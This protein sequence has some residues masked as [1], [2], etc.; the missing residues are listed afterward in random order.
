MRSSLYKLYKHTEQIKT[1]VRG[2]T[3]PMGRFFLLMTFASTLFGLNTNATMLYQLAAILLSFL[4]VSYILSL[5][6]SPHIS[7]TRN[8][9]LSCSAGEKLSYTLILHNNGNKKEKGFIY[10][11]EEHRDLPTVAEFLQT[12]ETYEKKRNIVDRKLKYYRWLWLIERKKKATLPRLEMQ[13]ILPGEMLEMDVYLTAEKRGYLHLQG[14]VIERYD[15]FGLFRTSVFFRKEK[16]IL[17]LPKI[18]SITDLVFDGSRKYH[19]G[20]ISTAGKYGDSEEFIALREFQAGDSIRH[21]DWKATAR[22]EKPIIRQY[23][24][25]FFSRYGIILDTFTSLSD[26]PV[27]EEAVSIA[28]SIVVKQNP[29]RSVVDLL[30]A[31][32]TFVS[33][34][35][36]GKGLAEQNH[37]LEILASVRTCQGKPFSELTG[38]VKSHANLLSGAVLIFITLDEQRKELLAYLQ[39]LQIPFRALLISSEEKKS[40]ATIDALD[41]TSCITVISTLRTNQEILLP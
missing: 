40:Q 41:L 7:I 15:P 21:I 5:R 31:G 27:F 9:P 20:G 26:C 36:M 22:Q 1:K 37:M 39:A 2:K 25:E 33:T 38:L 16:N 11:E 28:A 10:R 6:F 3:T 13:T 17:V 14:Y 24:D 32:N 8:I 30:F 18:Y 19:R 35:T 4:T 29:G 34:S 23:Q 12:P